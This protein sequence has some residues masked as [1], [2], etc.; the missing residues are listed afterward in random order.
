MGVNGTN[1]T[2]LYQVAQGKLGIFLCKGDFDLSA[3]VEAPILIS[4]ST[5]I[6]LFH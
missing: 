6:E 4:D 3:S 5:K 1:M 2:A